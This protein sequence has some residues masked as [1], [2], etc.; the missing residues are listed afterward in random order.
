[1]GIYLLIAAR[2][3][4]QARRRT[5][6]LGGALA[7]VTVLLVLF[8]SLMQGATENMIR[9]ATTLATG[10]VN[11][12]AF[13]KNTIT[14]VAP[15]VLD[16]AEVRRIV[17][18]NTPGVDYVID[19]QLGFGKIVSDRASVM[20]ALSGIEAAQEP[21][22]TEALTLAKESDYL[23]DGGDERKG[24]LSRIGE[25]GTIVLFANQAKRLK[26]Q[27][28]D[29]VTITA[30]T[31]KG[32]N[33]S[34]QLTV[35]AVAE[36]IGFISLFSTFVD[37]ADVRELYQL[38]ED[39][40]GVIMV[41]LKDTAKSAEVATH[42]RG[43]L[44]QKGYTMLEAESLPFHQ[45]L[46]SVASEDWTGQRMDVTTW[47]DELV[48]LTAIS[49]GLNFVG[50]LLVFILLAIIVVGIVN[51]MWISVRERTNE[52]GTLRAVGM[53]RRSVLTMFLT[54]AVLLGLGATVA[55][56]LV[57]ALIGAG[58]HAAQVKIPVDAFKM[59]LMADTFQFALTPGQLVFSVILLT[60]I[61]GVSAL[62]P[63]LKA[64]RMSPVTAIQA[65]N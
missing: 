52:I 56:S 55:G 21:R 12:G 26:V 65:V 49:S 40:T 48:M 33:N 42:L 13:Y 58:L 63:A 1:M 9:S 61:T 2:N 57:G 25:K 36:D 27:V 19:R 17:E 22:L 59:I 5:F 32:I 30:Q 62:W 3:L 54:E 23:P 20:S 29:A 11:V 10:H 46:Q 37:E 24:D 38:R 60:G 16:A 28:G 31:N 35:V 41:Y 53:Q 7:F 43:V 45:K 51:T 18:E 34:I 15:I 8:Q 47:E 64:A 44:A 6:L 39:T 4:M 14:S 50:F